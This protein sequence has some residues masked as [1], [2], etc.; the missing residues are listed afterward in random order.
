[1]A[2]LITTS[3]RAGDLLDHYRLECLVASGG[4]ASIFRAIDTNTSRPVAIKVPHPDKVGTSLVLDRFQLE[5]AMGKKFNHPG[6]VKV[7]PND[8]ASQRYAVMEWAEGKLLREI[9]DD[10][11]ALPIERAIR[12]TLAICNALEHVHSL[13]VVHRDLKPENV[14]VDA[15][16]NIKL[17]DFGIA[18]EIRVNLWNRLVREESMGTPG[19]VS[20]EQIKGKRADARADVYSLGIMLFEMLTGEVPFSGLDPLAAMNLRLLVDP[21]PASEINPAIS[22]RLQSVVECAL[23]RDPASRYPSARKF[24]SDLS[25]SLAEERE[26]QPLELLAN[27]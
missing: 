14:M 18:R 4:M 7:L 27:F 12:I 11:W 3:L 22:L 19:Y 6:L 17:L 13:G 23:A 2:L 8:G 21:P 20:P 25:A 24:A 26:A 5:I 1:M 9:I 15:K 10:R 16:D